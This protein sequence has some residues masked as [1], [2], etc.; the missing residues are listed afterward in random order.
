[1]GGYVNIKTF[2]HEVVGG[3]VAGKEVSVAFNVYSDQHRI[4]DARYLIYP[5]AKPAFSTVI[6]DTV[7]G[8]KTWLETN[9]SFFKPA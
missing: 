4:A 2:T 9:A 7:E 5:S 1:M 8:R 3:T 6:E